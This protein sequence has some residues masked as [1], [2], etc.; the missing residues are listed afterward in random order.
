VSAFC[1]RW[2]I[3][4]ASGFRVRAFAGPPNNGGFYNLPLACV[5]VDWYFHAIALGN[6]S[7]VNKMAEVLL[8]GENDETR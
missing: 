6:R 7:M 3:H 5:V 8:E 4:K 1:A 2:D